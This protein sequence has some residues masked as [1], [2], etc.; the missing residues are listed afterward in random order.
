MSENDSST[1]P[2]ED[3]AEALARELRETDFLL[4]QKIVQLETL[5]QA[6]LNLGG[7]LEVEEIVGEFLLLAIAMVDARGGFLFFREERTRDPSLVQHA[8]LDEAQ[9]EF[10][11][12][13]PLYEKLKRVM[14]EDFSLYLEPADLP[15]E[16]GR[17]HLLMVAVG[18]TGVVGVVD[19]E[20]RQGVEGFSE[21]DGHLLELVCQQAG[22]ALANARLYRSMDEERALNL[23]IVSSIANGV[24]STDLQGL[25]VR[26][27]PAVKRIFAAEE[28]LTGKSCAQLF[29]RYDCPGIAEAVQAS[30]QDGRERQV[31]AEQVRQGNLSLNARISPLRDPQGKV[32]GLVVALEDLTEQ[33][34]I[35]SM[36]KQYASDQVVDLLLSADSPPALGGENRDVAILFVDLVGSTELL[37]QIGAE[38]MV[39]L[40]N[41]CFTRLVDII[42]EYN[43]T[44]DKYTGDG[45]LAVFGAP[46]AFPDDVRRAAQSALAIREEMERFNQSHH[47]S[48]GIK[49]GISQGTATAGNIGSPRRMEYTVIGPS[50]SLGA[51]LSD[52]ARSGEIL[53]CAQVCE[54]LKEEFYF[55]SE[56]HQVFKG[57]REPI[58]VYQLVG[59]PGTRPPQSE[60]EERRPMKDKFAKIDLTIPMI[61]DMELTATQTAEA[62]GIFMGLDEDKIGEVKLALIEACINAIEHSQSKDG[63]LQIDFDISDTALTV[64][65]SDRGHGFDVN[66]VREKLRQRHAGGQRQRGWG[67]QLMEELMDE[68]GV[69]SDQNGTTIT[70]AKYR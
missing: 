27:N 36:F 41:D 8:N 65:I 42:F 32:Q 62:V 30:L 63:R 50:V 60:K 49:V 28:K 6:G 47:L 37:G 31:E 9:L 15:P 12:A 58:E 43:G 44:L 35:R 23:S 69:E 26:V 20:T 52:R 51:R 2:V 55:V 17:H 16:F 61:P 40:L 3:R 5:Y 67:L 68:V 39:R 13:G 34:R 66:E 54:E 14:L 64:V 25:V 10:L 29:R 22:T 48:W 38:K 56:G 7:S 1:S 57:I 45:F 59:S 46:V 70:M 18:K 33:T 53:V 19:K 21:A 24:I 11:R 4:N